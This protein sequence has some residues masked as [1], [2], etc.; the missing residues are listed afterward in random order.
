MYV[1]FYINNK[2]NILQSK[3]AV[4]TWLQVAATLN[5]HTRF[6]RDVEIRETARI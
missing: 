5:F 2:V 3:K 6:G 4:I 1:S